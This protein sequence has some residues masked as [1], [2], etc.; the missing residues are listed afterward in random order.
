MNR[1]TQ[2]AW[3]RSSFVNPADFDFIYIHSCILIVS[4]FIAHAF[5]RTQMM[6]GRYF[7]KRRLECFLWDGKTNYKMPDSIIHLAQSAA[8]S[9]SS[10]SSSTSTTTVASSSSSS[11]ATS[12]A[13]DSSNA[14]MF[15]DE[16]DA[17]MLAAQADEERIDS[18]GKWLEEQGSDED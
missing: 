14:Y 7:D 9:S 12:A 15:D 18:F 16:D 13:N 10:S 11:S 6:H 5:A 1:A 17:E 3:L 8:S 2:R 4:P